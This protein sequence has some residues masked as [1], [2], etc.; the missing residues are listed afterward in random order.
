MIVFDCWFVC[1][2]YQLEG[3][4]ESASLC[5]CNDRWCC[6]RCEVFHFWFFQFPLLFDTSRSSVRADCNIHKYIHSSSQLSC[7]SVWRLPA[8]MFATRFVQCCW[9][10]QHQKARNCSFFGQFFENYQTLRKICKAFLWLT[11]QCKWASSFRK[12]C[13]NYSRVLLNTLSFL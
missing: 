1:C 11:E 12:C 3:S 4:G 13:I 8:S 9:W 6:H 5:L 10:L 7:V 2:V